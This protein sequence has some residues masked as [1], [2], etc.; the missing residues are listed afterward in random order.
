MGKLI[1]P[2]LASPGMQRRVSL[3]YGS[4]HW[5]K[6]NG[7]RFRG[8]LIYSHIEV[9]TCLILAAAEQPLWVAEK[10]LSVKERKHPNY[11]GRLLL[12]AEAAP[13]CP[14][15]RSSKDRLPCT[16]HSTY[17]TQVSFEEPGRCT[18]TPSCLVAQSPNTGAVCT[19]GVRACAGARAPQVPPVILQCKT[20]PMLFVPL[21]EK[22]C[23]T[24][25]TIHV[26]PSYLR[27]QP[28]RLEKQEVVEAR[29]CCSCAPPTVCGSGGS[30]DS[31]ACEQT[32]CSQGGSACHSRAFQ[33][34]P[35][36]TLEKQQQHQL[37]QGKPRPSS[38]PVGRAEERAAVP[39]LGAFTA[40]SLGAARSESL[41]I[42]S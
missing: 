7:W 33:A 35:P 30:R 32:S 13:T 21:V 25:I 29:S 18:L 17:A 40:V 8:A 34:C 6:K 28:R 41:R 11:Q 5:S 9:F 3:S 37:R 27:L 31:I 16:P 12:C 39:G 23:L 42:C 2:V 38:R 14:S 36:V 15:C 19:V 26:V 20:P 10:Y 4:L 1:C 24:T 22:H